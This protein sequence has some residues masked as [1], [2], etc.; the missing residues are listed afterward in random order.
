MLIL[1]PADLTSGEG[2]LMVEAVGLLT[3]AVPTGEFID[4]LPLRAVLADPG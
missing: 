3:A 2:V 4:L 1:L